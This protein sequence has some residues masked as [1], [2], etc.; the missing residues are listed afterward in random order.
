MG[1]IRDDAKAV[2]LFRHA[3][4]L[5]AAEG[6]LNY[7]LALLRGNGGVKV[8]YQ[9]ALE[10]A[11]KS[12]AQGHTLAHQQLPMFF[13][14]A[15]NPNP[16]A[17]SLPTTKEELKRLGVKELRD[18]LRSEGIDFSDCVEKTDLIARA[19]MHLPGVAEP[20]DAAPEH[21]LLLE[22]PK[23]TRAELLKQRQQQTVSSAGGTPGPAAAGST[24]PA[25]A[26]VGTTAARPASS[27]VPASG[28]SPA[29]TPPATIHT[30]TNGTYKPTPTAVPPVPKNE[31]F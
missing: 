21:T 1:V 13:N 24:E 4:R 19:A 20:W 10:W 17:R 3:A 12:A 9:E 25:N 22:P 14:A 6:Q 2:R 11:Q 7:G 27:E 8:D 23:K 15:K 29:A 31:E 5:G 16:P 26:A 18:L 30:G 28:P